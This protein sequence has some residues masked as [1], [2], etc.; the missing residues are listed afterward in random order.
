MFEKIGPRMKRMTRLPGGPVLLDHF[1]A[2]DVGRHEIGREL[3]PVEPQVDGLGQL[4]DEQRLG[5]TGDAAEQQWPP[6]R[7]AI[8][9]SRM[10]RCCP[11][12]ALANSRSS[13]PATSATRSTETSASMSG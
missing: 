4:L 11:T 1:R 10:T 3:D 6:A 2:E 8:R 5:E 12:I 9:I 7:N 13:R